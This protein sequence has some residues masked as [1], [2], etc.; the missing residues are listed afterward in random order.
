M[1]S[2]NNA[3]VASLNKWLRLHSAHVRSIQVAKRLQLKHGS[4]AR[5]KL[6]GDLLTRLTTLHLRECLAQVYSV[7]P[8]WHLS[9]LT[10]LQSRVMTGEEDFV[11]P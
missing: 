8:T 6:P 9:S 11:E 3:Q 4:G 7:K 2:C 10:Y 1:A 5:L